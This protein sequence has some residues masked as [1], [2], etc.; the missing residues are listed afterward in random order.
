[1]NQSIVSIIIPTRFRSEALKNVLLDIAAQ[2]I[3]QQTIE[4]L[5]FNDGND[6]ETTQ[7]VKQPWPFRLQYFYSSEKTNSCRS[8]NVCLDHAQGEWIIFLDDDV[9]F[10]KTFLTW[11]QQQS[12]TYSLFSCRI[13]KP[14]H[15]QKKRGVIKFLSQMFL[16]GKTLPLLGFSIEGYE[17][18]LKHPIHVDHLVGAVMV[19]KHDLVRTIRFDEWIGEGTGFLDDLEFIKKIR[20][21][22]HIPAWYISSFDVLHLQAPSGGNREHDHKR[23]FYYYQAHKIY[24]FR[25]YFHSYLPTILIISFIEALLRSIQKRTNLIPTYVR[26]TQ[27]GLAQTI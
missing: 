1:M 15:N 4:V 2:T 27:Y 5:I 16:R 13:T 12:K 10:E 19:V 25:K 3:D 6:A 24:F 26:A 23:W 17:D 22:H 20:L 9:R 14:P 8:R 18:K 21:T 7:L 11:V